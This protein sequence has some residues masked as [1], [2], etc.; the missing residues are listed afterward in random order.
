[1]THKEF[2]KKFKK[3]GDLSA[4]M[5]RVSLDAMSDT[6]TLTP[7]GLIHRATAHVTEMSDLLDELIGATDIDGHPM[8]RTI[9]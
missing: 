3:L 6:P 2:K 7:N 1:M 9:G 4:E 5:I 8:T